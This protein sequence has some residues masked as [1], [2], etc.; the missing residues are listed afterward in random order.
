MDNRLEYKI[1]KLKLL[2][3]NIYDFALVKKKKAF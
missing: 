3:E 1:K 2:E